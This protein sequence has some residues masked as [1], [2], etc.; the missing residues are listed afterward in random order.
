M[1]K[2]TFGL[3]VREARTQKGY[4]LRSLAEKIGIDYSRLAKIE[5]GTRP[6]PEL[7]EVRRMSDVLDL[8]MAD[9]IVASGT[10]REVME[11]LLWSERLQEAASGADGPC[12]ADHLPERS[13]LLDKNTYR[14]DVV[15]R[16]GALCTLRLGEARIRAFS[17]SDDEKL[18]LRIPPEAV[19][20]H[21]SPT[22]AASTAENVLPM[23]VKKIRR[24]GQVT[25]LVL[26]GAGFEINTLHSGRSVDRMVLAME[27]VVCA[28]VQ[29][30]SLRVEPTGRFSYA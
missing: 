13:V 16:D 5:H 11:H 26:E 23:R 3:L 19:I 17:F 10:S 28:M 8:D 6:A 2:R 9:L 7:A 20:V 14:V 12:A 18:T 15:E 22:A 29:A 27:D 4:S 25:N 1:P 24:L 30:T 21:T